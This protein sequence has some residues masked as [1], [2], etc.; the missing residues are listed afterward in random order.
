MQIKVTEIFV[1]L[2]RKKRKVK[3]KY[4][5]PLNYLC[6][7]DD[8]DIVNLVRINEICTCKTLALFWPTGSFLA[9]FR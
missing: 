6:A 5:I 1:S 3:I 9:T 7:M 2:S 8:V 4:I